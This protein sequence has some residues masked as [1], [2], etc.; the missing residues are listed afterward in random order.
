MTKLMISVPE[1]LESSLHRRAVQAGFK[2]DEEYIVSLVQA[3]CD[4]AEL[5][6]LLQS[7]DAATVFEVMPEVNIQT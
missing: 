4:A 7:R 5:E 2:S 3:D 1:S 6:A